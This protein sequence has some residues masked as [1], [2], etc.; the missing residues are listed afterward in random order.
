VDQAST[1]SVI[2]TLLPVGPGT[3]RWLVG[4]TTNRLGQKAHTTI[5]IC[6]AYVFTWSTILFFDLTCAHAF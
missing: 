2:G 6:Y 1:Q 5:C 4:H 3:L